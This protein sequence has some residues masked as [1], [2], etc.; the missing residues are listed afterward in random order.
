M[1]SKENVKVTSDQFNASLLKN[2][3]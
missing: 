1:F 3:Y 2:Y